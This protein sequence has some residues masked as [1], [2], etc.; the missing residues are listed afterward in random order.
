MPRSKAGRYE[1]AAT[2]LR[3]Q[4]VEHPEDVA[5]W[6]ALGLAEVGAGR[7]EQ[8]ID[9]WQ[10]WSANDPDRGEDAAALMQAARTMVEALREARD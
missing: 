7:F 1:E 9:A 2:L 6:R 4:V 8:A 10:S 5:A 3:A